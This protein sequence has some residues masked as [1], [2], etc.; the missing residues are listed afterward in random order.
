[1]NFL[2]KIVE[3]PN[4]G[5]EIALVEGVAVTLGKDDSCDI[6][7]ADS[8]LPDAPIKLDPT[9]SGVTADG[10]EL[11]PFHVRTF[12]ATSLVVGPSDAPWG[13]LVWPEKILSDGAGG[14]EVPS[15]PAPAGDTHMAEDVPATAPSDDGKRRGGCLGCIVALLIFLALLIVLGC[16]FRETVR[17]HA[18]SLW[19]KMTSQGRAAQPSDRG[20]AESCDTGISDLV[21]RHGLLQTSANGRTVLSGNFPT[22]AE[23]LLVTAGAYASS[24]GIELDFSDDETLRTAAEDTLSLLGESGL[25]VAVATNRVLA[26]TGSSAR[27]RRTLEALNADIPKL[28]AVNV[29]DVVLL[30]DAPSTAGVDNSSAGERVDYGSERRKQQRPLQIQAKANPSLPV[31]GILTTPYPCLVL[32][33]GTRV[34]EGAPIGDSVV[35]K[36]EADSVTITNAT[37]RFT[38][39]P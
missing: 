39:K 5:A 26:L 17:P 10:T 36:I 15:E 6:V 21:A 9:S 31:C 4:K 19:N 30:A 35:L 18:E 29:A 23:R 33:N 11:E 8:T 3:G 34:L 25:H 14:A 27:L 20:D 13:E 1:M 38:W 37:G 7:L 32:R 28:R 16:F 22:R 24:P 12:G 2:L